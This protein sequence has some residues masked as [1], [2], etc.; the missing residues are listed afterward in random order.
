MKEIGTRILDDL[1][2]PPENQR[3][4]YFPESFHPP[5]CVRRPRQD[6][7]PRPPLQFGEPPPPTHPR[8]ALSERPE[9]SRFEEAEV[10]HFEG[11]EWQVQGVQLVCRG[12]PGY[13]DTSA[14]KGHWCVPLLIL[15]PARL[16]F[17][18]NMY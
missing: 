13:R 12:R 6:G 9:V 18:A 8:V 10:S 3:Y 11:R 15:I 17:R 7:L 2:I 5:P 16:P 14:G 1:G 4:A